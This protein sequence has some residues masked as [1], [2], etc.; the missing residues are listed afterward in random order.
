GQV[1][2]ELQNTP[3][4]RELRR[5]FGGHS[6]SVMGAG[7]GFIVDPSGVIVTNNHVV[8]HAS[9]ITVSLQD[10][11]KLPAAVIGADQLTDVAVIRVHAPHPLPFVRWGDSSKVQVGDWV[12]TAG[13]PFGLGATVSAGIISA[14]GRE[15]GAGPF[16][17]F[18]QL[19]A[20]INPGNSGGPAFN[21]QGQ[22]IGMTTAIVSPTGGSV[23]IGFAI[24]SDLIHP[25]V[26]KLE[27]HGAIPRGWLGVAAETQPNGK[28]GG[29]LIAS[30][31]HDSPAARAGLRRGD[32]VLRVDGTRMNT[33]LDLVRAIAERAPDQRV[34]LDILRGRRTVSV[35]VTVGRRPTETS[36]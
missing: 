21:T 26:E 19:D 3:L 6:E 8:G 34:K 18:L 7:S 4:G 35:P 10:G 25:I 12:L 2:P 20:S 31:E 11:E 23:G 36:E 27:A 22:V 32:V 30:V 5:R 13:N 1:P 9:R 15:L 24:P 14:R 16:D 33:A 29:V 17:H 28:P